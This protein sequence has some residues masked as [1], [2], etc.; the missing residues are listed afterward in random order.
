MTISPL[1][2]QHGETNSKSPPRRPVVIAVSYNGVPLSRGHSLLLLLL[3]LEVRG[4]LNER[5]P[6]PPSPPPPPRCKKPPLLLQPGV[7]L[8]ILPR[9][10]L[11]AAIV[12]VAGGG[13]DGSGGERRRARG[14]LLQ[15][16][17]FYAEIRW[18]SGHFQSDPSHLP[19][20]RETPFVPVFTRGSPS[21]PLQLIV[22]LWDEEGGRWSGCRIEGEGGG[23]LRDRVKR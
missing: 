4:V 18:L 19:S 21:P 11:A 7:T 12:A 1:P 16:E 5:S 22:C 14:R 6:P 10:R 8:M 3:L 9:T 15:T 20:P 23:G 13:G 2:T 17:G